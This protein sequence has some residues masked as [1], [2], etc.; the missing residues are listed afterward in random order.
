MLN[1]G[2][3]IDRDASD[4]SIAWDRVDDVTLAYWCFPGDIV[5]QAG[6]ADLST[7]WGWV[8]LLGFALQMTHVCHTIRNGEP[9][10][11]EILG[12]DQ[13][14]RFV[15]VGDRIE[16]A[17]DYSDRSGLATAEELLDAS[18]LMLARLR[19]EVEGRHPGLLTNSR[20]RE[21]VSKSW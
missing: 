7:R 20:Y 2:Y 15:P 21:L 8:P 5:L 12:S 1:L 18:V 16:I 13:C 6:G 17:A 3:R 11:L 19:A 14:L 4:E 10:V 9:Q